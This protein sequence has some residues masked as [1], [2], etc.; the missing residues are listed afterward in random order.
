[1]ELSMERIELSDFAPITAGADRSARQS[2]RRRAPFADTVL[3]CGK[4]CRK[5]DAGKNLRKAVQAAIRTAYA[6][7]V[8]LEKVDCFSLCPKNGQVLATGAG[9]NRRL[10][11]V[12]PSS[13]IELAVAYLL[14]NPD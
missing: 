6:D 7:T 9:Q 11:I 13:D 4:C 14:R 2:G 1:M 8:Q 5:L 3:M 10:V 12:Q